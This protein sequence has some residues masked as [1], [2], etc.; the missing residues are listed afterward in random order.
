[1]LNYGG[2][3]VHVVVCGQDK[4]KGR[5]ARRDL[6]REEDYGAVEGVGKIL[7]D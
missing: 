6:G 1:M 5:A 7:I 2:G 3:I 4:V